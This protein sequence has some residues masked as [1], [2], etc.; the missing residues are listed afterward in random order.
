MVW[1]VITLFLHGHTYNVREPFSS[2]KDCVQAS[3]PYHIGQFHVVDVECEW[4][5]KFTNPHH[6]PVTP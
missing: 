3:Q 5:V 4:T 2:L 6:I 1:L